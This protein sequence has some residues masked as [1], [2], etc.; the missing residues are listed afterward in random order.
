M[1]GPQGNHGSARILVVDDELFFPAAVS[2]AVYKRK[3]YSGH[4]ATPDT[5]NADDT[6]FRNGGSKGLLRLRKAGA[7]YAGAIAMGVNVS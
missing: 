4:G 5:L 7:G 2:N 1:N 3:P 6:I